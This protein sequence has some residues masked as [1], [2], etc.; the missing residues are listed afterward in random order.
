MQLANATE[1]FFVRR[2]PLYEVCR[3]DICQ[4]RF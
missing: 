1:E 2:S 3:F 4:N